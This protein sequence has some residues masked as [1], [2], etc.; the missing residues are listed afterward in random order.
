MQFNSLSFIFIFLPITV[1]LYFCI[2]K[3]NKRLGLISLLALSISFYY[4]FGIKEIA[5]VLA[6][7]IINCLNILIINKLSKKKAKKV[8]LII[9]ITINISILLYYKYTNFIV[10]NIVY[11]AGKN[12]K[13]YNIIM[14]IG[15]SFITF[16]QIAYLVD[17]YNKEIS[18][19]FLDYFL[20]IFYFPKIV[21]GPI[22]EPNF[23]IKQFHDD[24]KKGVNMDNVVVG[25][26]MFV[27][28]LSKKMLL[29]DIFSSVAKYGYSHI[30]YA[31]SLE[32][33]IAVL[34]YSFQIYFDFSGYSDMAIGVSRIFNIDLPINF[35]SPYKA[36]SFREFWRRWHISLTMFFKKYVYIPLGGSRKGKIRTIINNMIVFILSGIWHGANW[37]FILWG[38]LHGIGTVIG[39]HIGRYTS[40]IYTFISWLVTFNLVS[41]LWW[42]FGG[43]S[44]RNWISQMG[45]MIHLRNIRIGYEISN[46]FDNPITSTLEMIFKING[47]DIGIKGLWLIVYFIV[48]FIICLLFKN[49]YKKNYKNTIRSIIFTSLLFVI[50][51]TYLNSESVFIYGGF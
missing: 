49:S 5:I 40:R 26:R 24:S 44:I 9:G 45:T 28:G 50:S 27:I 8:F 37:T 6:S 15:I 41:I 39:R 16:H 13:P 30:G 46:C 12:F 36:T 32:I 25:I 35:D 22:T 18:F 11:C 1:I 19:N 38:G 47:I 17:C 4:F 48:G 34:S 43:D 51:L 14:P 20:Y 3:C 42:L 33:L 31:S 23:L 10:S 29:A 2:S 21:M 7:S